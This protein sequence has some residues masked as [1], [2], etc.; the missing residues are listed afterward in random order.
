MEYLMKYEDSQQYGG[1][2]EGGW[3]YNLGVPQWKFGIP[4]PMPQELR[5]KICRKLNEKIKK[6]N[7]AQ[8]YEY[9]SVLSDRCEYF[10]FGTEE[11]FIPQQPT[12]PHYE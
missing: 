12:R 9:T 5:Y 6:Q 11:S 2:E 8:E 3:W 7:D 10:S 4:L 1:P